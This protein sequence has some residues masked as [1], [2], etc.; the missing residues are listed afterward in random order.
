MSGIRRTTRKEPVYGEQG[1]RLVSLFRQR[2]ITISSFQP[3]L[4]YDFSE[5]SLVTVSSGQAV[6]VADKGSR[7]WNLTKSA[8]GPQYVTG[9]NGLK[10]IDW[11]STAH[12]NY[13]RNTSST[14]TTL[15]DIYI[16]LDASFGASFPTF[17]GLVSNT[18]DPGWTVYG[19]GTSLG[20]S[21]NQAYINGS[22]TD[23][24]ASALP[25]INSPSLLRLND[26]TTPI[27]STGGFQIGSERSNTNRGWYG[28]IGEV[29]VFS[30]VLSTQ[31]SAAVATE[32][33]S[34]W[35]ISP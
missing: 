6:S 2:A 26:S 30:N 18:G 17:A 33:M 35:G 4:W 15:A 27:V 16:V 29:V 20:G 32:L 10:C 34:K 3:V 5:E 8:T 23:S 22:T 31:D 24:I 19:I 21:V 13:L 7:G 12:S 11:G 28:L 14:S 25:A 9:I 1:N